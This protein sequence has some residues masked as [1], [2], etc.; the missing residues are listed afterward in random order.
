MHRN[1]VLKLLN[2]YIPVYEEEIKAK[3]DIISFISSN[4]QCFERSLL[5]GHITASAWL[6]NHTG[7]KVLLMHHK[8]LG[9]WMQ[10]G[11]HC[12][13]DSDVL[14]VAAKEA[15]EESGIDDIEMVFP[16]IFDLDIHLV[17]ENNKENAH[18]H[19]DIRFLMQVQGDKDFVKNHESN[20]L[21]WVGT[22]KKEL[23]TNAR[24][25]TR[26]Y[27]KWLSLVNSQVV[28]DLAYTQSESRIRVGKREVE[29]RKCTF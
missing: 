6:I 8:K 16:S 10:F 14:L 29:E 1:L 3:E 9:E 28:S 23:P 27:E 4:E 5:S 7:D 25:I 26:M 19:Y 2:D 15:K 12:D 11:G 22:N 21:R 17:P 13:G 24:S 18:Y 20:E